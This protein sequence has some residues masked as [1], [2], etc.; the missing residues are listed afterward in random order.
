[1]LISVIVTTYNSVT[2]LV[3]SLNSFARQTAS[4]FEVVVADDGSTN[5]TRD[6][7]L[8]LQPEM[9]FPLVHVRQE[10]HGFRVARVRN[11]ALNHASG[12]YIVFVDGDCFVLPDFV[13]VHR[14]LAEPGYFVSGKRSWLREDF[15]HRWLSAPSYDGRLSWFSRALRNQCTRP[16]EFIPRK[17]GGG[18]ALSEISGLERCLDLQ[19]WRVARE[20]VGDQRIRQSLSGAWPGGFRFRSPI[21]P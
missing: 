1:M 20:R 18:L 8:S 17:D 3:A 7:I 4:D 10:N 21:D 14:R 6:A 2:P 15:T 9:P 5:E 16:L 13:A 19:S 12:E 11:L